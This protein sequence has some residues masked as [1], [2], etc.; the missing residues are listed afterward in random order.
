MYQIISVSESSE[1]SV[2]KHESNDSH[3]TLSMEGRDVQV[4]VSRDQLQQIV[5]QAYDEHGM[6][7]QLW[8]ATA[9]A[10]S[11]ELRHTFGCSE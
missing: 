10:R 4:I 9:V 5:Q 8:T 6:V 1:V 11:D 7:P 2:E 3:M